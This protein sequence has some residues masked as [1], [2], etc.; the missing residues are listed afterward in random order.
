MNRRTHHIT[1]FLVFHYTELNAFYQKCEYE[2][3]NPYG[4]SIA[5]YLYYRTRD[6]SS[7]S[8][9]YIPLG[10]LLD[11]VYPHPHPQCGRA[12]TAR[13]AT[14]WPENGVR[15]DFFGCHERWYS[16]PDLKYL[17]YSKII[18]FHD[19][20]LQILRCG[21]VDVLN[22][23]CLHFCSVK[24]MVSSKTCFVSLGLSRNLKKQ[25]FFYVCIEITTSYG[26][27]ILSMCLFR[28]TTTFLRCLGHCS[29]ITKQHI[30]LL[31]YHK[32]PS[33]WECESMIVS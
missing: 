33:F 25:E 29:E 13:K 30:G 28:G 5:L 7:R 19:S 11:S 9:H 18:I 31:Y 2:Y 22:W 8:N 15:L 20:R 1:W 24:A 17:R 21:W 14:G 23:L 3:P 10:S 4:C 26:T 16:H 12:T 32:S 6:Y 27:F